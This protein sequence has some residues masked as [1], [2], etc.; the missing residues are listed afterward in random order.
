MAL[1]FNPSC[2]VVAIIRF[3]QEC[4]WC[5]PE[6]LFLLHAGALYKWWC[7]ETAELD[8]SVG[9]NKDFLGIKL[10]GLSLR[11]GGG[12]GVGQREEQVAEKQ[13]GFIG[14][15][16]EW[17]FEPSLPGV[18]DLWG[19]VKG[20]FCKQKPSDKSAFLLN[21]NCWAC[22]PQNNPSVSPAGFLLF[23]AVSPALTL[24]TNGALD[25]TV[26]LR[27]QLSSQ[28]WMCLYIK[29]VTFCH[30]SCRAFF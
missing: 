11:R 1:A 20:G 29:P 17:G 5:G 16:A 8:H 25:P 19:K 26:F 6:P 13:T 24:W 4:S 27:G 15:V 14:H 7:R 2:L 10:P 9:R 21:R 3:F 28:I 18:A 23:G 12:K 30:S 22:L